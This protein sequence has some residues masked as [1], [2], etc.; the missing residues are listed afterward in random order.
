[1]SFGVIDSNFL[2]I[3]EWGNIKKR[4]PPKKLLWVSGRP[5]LLIPHLDSGRAKAE[6]FF[7]LF[8]KP[9]QFLGFH[10]FLLS[11]PLVQKRFYFL[12]KGV[13]RFFEKNGNSGGMIKENHVRKLYTMLRKDGFLPR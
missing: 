8:W 11:F 4:T 5:T 3:L 7:A 13:S 9:S 12:K 10:A 1:M 6:D 2:K